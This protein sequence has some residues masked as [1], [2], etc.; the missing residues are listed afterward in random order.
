MPRWRVAPLLMAPA[1]ALVACSGDGGGT[2]TGRGAGYGSP[3]EEGRRLYFGR[4]TACHSPE[5]V[6]DY[7]PSEW[8]T[9]VPDMAAESNLTAAQT[10][11]L[12][13]YIHAELAR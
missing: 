6:R 5:P 1:T 9:I 4:C 11:A 8:K 3:V 13:A 12:W 10:D 2:S 7:S